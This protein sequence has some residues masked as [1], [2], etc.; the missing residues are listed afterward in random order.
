[1]TAVWNV[2][3]NLLVGSHRAVCSSPRLRPPRLVSPLF[4]CLD[5]SDQEI[6][7]HLPSPSDAPLAESPPRV[8]QPLPTASASGSARC[9]ESVPLS[10]SET[11]TGLSSSAFASYDPTL[12]STQT[13]SAAPLAAKIDENLPITRHLPPT[14][15]L[16]G[17]FLEYQIIGGARCRK[18]ACLCWERVLQW[19][20]AMSLHLR[21]LLVC[22]AAELPRCPLVYMQYSYIGNRPQPSSA[23]PD[24]TSGC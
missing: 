6:H 24:P 12:D 9:T 13:P 5:K 11:T 16:D 19:Q 18:G 2:C 21:L 17:N 20:C 14:S 1:V 10:R 15:S 23:I 3:P 7:T 22:Y 8:A 4:L